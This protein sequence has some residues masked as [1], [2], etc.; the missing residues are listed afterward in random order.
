[1]KK[2]NRYV[3][4]DIEATGLNPKTERIIEI[5]AVRVVDGVITE[6][7]Q[8]LVN[9]QKKLEDRIVELTGISQRELEGEPIISDVIGRVLDFVGED[10][11]L[12]HSILSDYS[13]LK[14]AAV[15]YQFSFEKQGIDTLKIARIYL[16][17]LESKRL[18]DLCQHFQIPIQ[19]HRALEDARATAFLYEKM[20]ETITGQVEE[21]YFFP[22]PLIYKVKRET[23]I[24]EKQKKRLYMLLDKH[25]ITE[26]V[27]VESMTRNEAS[28]YM[29]LLCN[30]V[31]LH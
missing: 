13:F 18:G 10:C 19:A 9:P 14:R 8:Q 27:V 30:T 6:T 15:N 17:Q 5:G 26:E 23:S 2:A 21:R 7:F 25:K 28:R 1:M 24:T 22:V 4:I 31:G 3:A 16:P 12:G 11:L 20:C 29:D